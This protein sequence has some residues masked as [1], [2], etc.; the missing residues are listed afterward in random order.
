L[1][2]YDFATE[3]EYALV[4]EVDDDDDKEIGEDED[5]SN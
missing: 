3:V 4:D 1:S 5:E 2:E